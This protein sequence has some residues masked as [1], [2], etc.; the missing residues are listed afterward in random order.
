[1]RTIAAIGLLLLAPLTA[2]AQA[3]NGTGHRAVVSKLVDH[4]PRGE[5]EPQRSDAQ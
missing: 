1:M 2:F 3:Q 4:L 5:L